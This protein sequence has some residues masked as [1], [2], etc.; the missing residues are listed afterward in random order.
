MSTNSKIEWTNHTWN[1]VTG[2]T[3]VSAGCKNCYAEKFFERFNGKGSF[4]KI[5]CHEDR[6]LIPKKWKKPGMVFVNSMSDLFHESVPFY[7]IDKVFAIMALCPEHIFQVL[8]KRPERMMQYFDS[9]EDMKSICEEAEILV[10][11]EPHLFHVCER[12]RGEAKRHIGNFSISN[13]LKP[14]LKEAGWFWDFYYSE[15][16]KV[17]SLNFEGNWPLQNVWLGTSIENQDTAGRL[18]YL[19]NT[20]AAVRFIS[21]EPLL[22]PVQLNLPVNHT[23]L[24]WVIVGGESGT[25]ARPMQADWVNDLKDQ[26]T[27]FGIP[28]FFK[29][30]GGKNKKKAGRLLDGKEYN[31]M[32]L[33]NWK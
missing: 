23:Y 5:T 2:C 13:E 6:L 10:S 20:P 19:L 18:D 28:F 14:N 15:F 21:C 16:G 11:T 26:C 33:V 31:Q 32:P 27:G 7:F 30:W 22:G 25:G 9:R 12:L 24:H 8:T 29:Q 17:Y 1:P 4:K 3:K